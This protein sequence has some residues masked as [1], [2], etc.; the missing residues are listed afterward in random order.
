MPE[1]DDD[2]LTMAKVIFCDLEM[3]A[4]RWLYAAAYVLLAQRETQPEGIEIKVET[5]R[6]RITYLGEEEG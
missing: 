4:K 6:L 3:P 5:A 2:D 1:I